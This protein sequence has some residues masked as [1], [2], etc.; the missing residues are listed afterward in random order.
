MVKATRDEGKSKITGV[1]VVCQE[2]KVKK[3]KA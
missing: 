1:K 3:F 2:K